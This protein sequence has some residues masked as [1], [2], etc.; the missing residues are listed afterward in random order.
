MTSA[1]GEPDGETL[2]ELYQRLE[3]KTLLAE[4]IEGSAEG[5]DPSATAGP[6]VLYETV[7]DDAALER[8]L[9]KLSEAELFAFDTETTSLDYMEAQ[10]VGVSFAV[11]A[12]EAAYVP[13]AH[14]YTGAPDQLDR[15][16]VLERM[17]P[18]LEDP[19]KRER[20]A[21]SAE[22]WSRARPSPL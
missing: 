16:D 8:W 2:R 6:E 10:V 3:F 13:L 12:G 4:Q 7:L 21:P 22:H 18:L 19:A 1:T 14:A 11:E 5:T 9:E 15:D 20:P 17:R